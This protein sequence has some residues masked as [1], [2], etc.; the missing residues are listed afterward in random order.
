MDETDRLLILYGSQTFTA[1]ESAERIWRT[2][3]TVGFKGPVLP[4][5]NY[6]ISQLIHEKFVLFVCATTGQGD[7]P[8]NMKKFWRFLLRKN[9][10]SN[11]LCKVKFGVLGLGDSSYSKFNFV[12][13]K[14]HKRLLQLGAEPLIDIGKN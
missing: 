4:M 10:P 11:S 8:D 1:Q 12:A 5:D 9:L 2:M 7:E 6:P 3:K 14:L 13:K